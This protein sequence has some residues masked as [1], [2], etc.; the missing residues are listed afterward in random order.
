MR[1]DVVGA[2]RG[3]GFMQ[4]PHNDELR[5]RGVLARPGR[6]WSVIFIGLALLGLIAAGVWFDVVRKMVVE[7]PPAAPD[8]SA[9]MAKG[10]EA[11]GRGDYAEAVRLDRIAAEQGAPEAKFNL[12][13]AY[14][15]GQGV[16]QDDVEAVRWYRLAADQGLAQAQNLLAA[17][18]LNGQGVTQDH[19]EAMRLYHLAADQ[20]YAAA[21]LHLGTI[22][23]T[24]HGVPQDYAEALVWYRKA[25]NHDDPAAQYDVGLIYANGLGVPADLAVARQWIEK[26][27]AH[28]ENGA[29]DWLA[30]H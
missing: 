6:L 4:E 12:G 27:A 19:A 26:A 7:A 28:N 1:L 18:Y 25:A 21:Q 24:G 10:A 22:Y 30:T 2:R 15:Q 3:A 23:A 13:V 11:R 14:S 8:I 17:A 16:V 5:T 20:E 29:K 9:V